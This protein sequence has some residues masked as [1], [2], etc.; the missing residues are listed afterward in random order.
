MIDMLPFLTYAFSMRIELTQA[1]LMARRS[2]KERPT[3][4]RAL[5]Q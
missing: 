1:E 2:S 5:E 4:P 3:R